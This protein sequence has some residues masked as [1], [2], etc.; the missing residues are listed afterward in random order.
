MENI[1]KRV[2]YNKN[3]L[4]EVI[5][6]LRFPTI[7]SI[8]AAEPVEFQ[9]KIRK[10]FP[11]YQKRIN[12][13]EIDVNG[14][15]QTLGKE[16]NYEFVSHDRGTKINLTSSFFAVSSIKYDRWEFFRNTIEEVRKAFEEVYQPQFYIRVGLRYQDVIDRQ[17]LN[18][19]NKGWIDLIQ[20]HILGTINEKNQNSLKQWIVNCEFSDEETK[21]QTRQVFQLSQKVGTNNLVIVFDCDYFLV[22]TIQKDKVLEIS[23]QLHDKSSTF[24]RNA[25]TSTLHE[26]ME[27]VELEP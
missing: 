25:I 24:I 27:P 11:F 18:L 10:E 7:L 19:E 17:V 23:N 22:D 16:I 6:Q 9:E 2:K 5:Y 14:V 21:V 15:K 1:I 12:T 13:N 26:A 4:D 20:P 3:P 8:N